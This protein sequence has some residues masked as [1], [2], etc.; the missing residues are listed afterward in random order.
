MPEEN[1]E[2]SFLRNFREAVEKYY[3]AADLYDYDTERRWIGELIRTARALDALRP[4]GRNALLPL[5]EDANP[6]VQ[7]MAAIYLLNW[8]PEPA[9][10]VLR[11]IEEQM[12]DQVS[13]T[14]TWGLARYESGDIKI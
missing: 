14:A 3:Q 1:D 13:L 12:L 6:G 7:V 9:L 8:V 5:L 4:G 2:A 11:D 10:R